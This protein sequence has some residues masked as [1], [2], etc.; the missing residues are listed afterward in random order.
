MLS[1][2]K[3]VNVSQSAWFVQILVTWEVQSRVFSLL[4]HFTWQRVQGLKWSMFVQKEDLWHGVGN[5]AYSS[6]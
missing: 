3:G 1:T 2:M 5:L 6:I 4:L